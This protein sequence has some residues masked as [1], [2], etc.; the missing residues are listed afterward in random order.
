MGIETKENIVDE[1]QEMLGLNEEGEIAAD[2]ADEK[3]ADKAAETPAATETK[4]T[5]ALVTQA[6]VDI[7]K[8]ILKIDM[9]IEELASASVDLAAFYETLEESLNEEEQALEFSDKPAYMKMVAQ[10]AKEYETSNS[11]ADAIAELNAQKKELEFVSERQSAIVEVSALYPDYDHEKVLEFYNNELS[12]S[13]QDKIMAASTSY[14]E[15]YENTY[16]KYL[17]I[18][19]ANI[20]TT[21]AP[22]I[23]NLNNTRRESANNKDTDDGL[24]SHDEL[25]K[26]ALGL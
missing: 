2:I 13:E 11:K 26:Q 10:K 5:P 24:S 19:P 25:L 20:H 1:L 8:D 21:P 6:Q 22:N 12:K 16:K 4:Q 17:T 9:K 23:P 7:Q 3:E 14:K 18:N 15:V